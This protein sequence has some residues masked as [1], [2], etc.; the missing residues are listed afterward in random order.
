MREIKFMF[1]YAPMC[2]GLV[3]I[4]TLLYLY[5]LKLLKSE[6]NKTVIAYYLGAIES[7]AIY[8]KHQYW[9]LI[10]ANF[11]H[12]DF[13]HYL[14][15]LY[16]IIELGSW[17][18]ASMTPWLFA[19][20]LV[21]SGLAST[22]LTYGYDLKKGYHHVTFGAS[23]FGFGFLGFIAGLMLFHHAIAPSSM[24]SFISVI[25]INVA[26]TLM[27]PNIS[28]TGHLGGFIGGLLVSLLW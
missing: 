12:V 23:G 28:K 17:L 24:T 27:R 15:N 7:Q 8:Q 3:I 14:F 18:E 26:Y 13:W 25:L 4:C 16:F 20:L 5:T 6:K 21:V 22:V 19:L 2:L 1:N 9:R 11:I 10:A